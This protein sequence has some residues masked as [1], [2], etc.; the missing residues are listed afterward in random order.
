MDEN[1]YPNVYAN[2]FVTPP[3]RSN[4]Y[5]CGDTTTPANGN[6][7]MTMRPVYGKAQIK[8]K[9]GN[10][11]VDSLSQLITEQ[12]NG[13]LGLRKETLQS[14][15]NALTDKLFHPEESTIKEKTNAMKNTTPYFRDIALKP[16]T[17]NIDDEFYTNDGNFWDDEWK[18]TDGGVCVDIKPPRTSYYDN[19][20]YFNLM[21][22]GAVDELARQNY[23]NPADQD[24]V[25]TI[26]TKPDHI[27]R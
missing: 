10:Y 4:L 1:L 14:F 3:T 27:A 23:S 24:N 18:R 15:S 22:Q 11:S 6:Q 8:I 7:R 16:D 25:F 17:L 26:G 2:Q 9:A 12:L 13:S 21:V 5:M 20:N 19:V